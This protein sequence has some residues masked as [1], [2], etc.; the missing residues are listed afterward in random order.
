MKDKQ[1]N[2][3][4]VP[5]IHSTGIAE[6]DS[7]VGEEDPGADLDDPEMR[8]ALRGEQ[9]IANSNVVDDGKAKK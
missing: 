5:A 6:D 8:D 2:P 1:T 4:A 9:Q 7:S 3:T